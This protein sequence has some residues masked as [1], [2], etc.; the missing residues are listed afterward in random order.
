MFLPVEAWEG[1]V[2]C[3]AWRWQQPSQLWL[4]LTALLCP[5]THGGRD[6]AAAHYCS[7]PHIKLNG[8]SVNLGNMDRM[9]RRLSVHSNFQHVQIVNYWGCGWNQ[10]TSTGN[11]S[12]MLPVLQKQ[13]R[14]TSTVPR[15]PKLLLLST[16]VLRAQQNFSISCWLSIW[17]QFLNNVQIVKQGILEGLTASAEL[18]W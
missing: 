2:I 9:A 8:S 14:Y 15:L 4:S 6:A 13:C 10:T 5:C 1:S 3:Q 18:I 16:E 12:F 17:Y 11:H 7:R